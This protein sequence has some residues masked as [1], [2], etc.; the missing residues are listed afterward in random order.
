MNIQKYH[1]L[2]LYCD[3]KLDINNSKIADISDDGLTAIIGF[4]NVNFETNK[5]QGHV[6]VFRKVLDE[7]ILYTTI[8]AP[9]HL[10]Y[11]LFGYLIKISGDGKTIAVTAIHYAEDYSIN[12]Y[13]CIYNLIDNTWRYQ[14]ILTSI[15][16]A[17]TTSFGETVGLSFDGK[18]LVTSTVD[19]INNRNI[20]KVYI[21]R[22]VQSSWIMLS[23]TLSG[24]ACVENFGRSLTLSGDGKRLAVCAT[25][26]DTYGI[27][28]IYN[29]IGDIVNC[30]KSIVSEFQ[31]I[32]KIYF[33]MALSHNGDT[34]IV[35]DP[36]AKYS[37]AYYQDGKVASFGKALVYNR[38]GV[39]WSQ[40]S[41][42]IC[43]GDIANRDSATITSLAIS[44]DG[45][46]III[47][48]ASFHDEGCDK[49]SGCLY[50]YELIEDSWKHK[51]T[52][53][54]KNNDLVS[55]LG[56]CV[57]ASFTGDDILAVCNEIDTKMNRD[58]IVG[59]VGFSI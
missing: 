28:Y 17:G 46:K 16:N 24:H 39:T 25:N 38:V 48:D 40:T 14:G 2:N 58:S 9:K 34:L 26:T 47:G 32:D 12:S 4:P 45:K 37:A 19:S 43:L 59:Y 7:W 44:G 53:T 21:Y 18:L 31:Y 52:F 8:H 23:N 33:N 36:E 1:K 5:S 10:T 56:V 20:G 51:L 11:D 29:I 27:I 35:S 42:D 22:L 49:I 3:L 15:D 57:K 50:V 55:L 6:Y 13:I 30:E 41:S 54:P